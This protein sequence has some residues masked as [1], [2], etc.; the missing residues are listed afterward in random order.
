MTPRGHTSKSALYPA[1]YRHSTEFEPGPRGHLRLR[2]DWSLVKPIDVDV[3]DNVHCSGPSTEPFT[4]RAVYEAS[5]NYQ[6][7]GYSIVTCVYY[8]AELRESPPDTVLLLASVVGDSWHL[9]L[10]FRCTLT[11]ASFAGTRNLRKS[12][13]ACVATVYMYDRCNG[14]RGAR[15]DRANRPCMDA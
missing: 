7:A 15:K 11:L 8:A 2:P 1:S 5:A 13:Q 9:Q 10:S 12:F 6:L 14:S 4:I 3:D